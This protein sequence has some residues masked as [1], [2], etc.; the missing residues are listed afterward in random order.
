MNRLNPSRSQN[1][2]ALD[3]ALPEVEKS[4][5]KAGVRYRG[6]R[7]AP[8]RMEEVFISLIRRMEA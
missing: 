7:I 5:K 2:P 1:F 4:L 6:I 8:A 3:E